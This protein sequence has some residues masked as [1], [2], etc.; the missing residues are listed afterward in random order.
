MSGKVHGV[1]MQTLFAG[2]PARDF[3]ASVD[4]YARLFGR[5]P[6]VVAHEHEVLWR[7]SDTGWMYVG[8][9]VAL[10]VVDDA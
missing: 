10:I 7:V 8:N 9:S 3:D 1:Q 2:V 6:D 4:W 5:A